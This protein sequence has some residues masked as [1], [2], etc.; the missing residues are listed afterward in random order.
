VIRAEASADDQYAALDLAYA[1]LEMRLRKVADRRRIHYGRHSPKSVADATAALGG[2]NG[3]ATAGTK[4]DAEAEDDTETDT[5]AD[6]RPGRGVS[7][8]ANPPLIQVDGEGPLVMRE[9]VHQASPMTLDQ[10][11]YEMELVGHDFYLFVDAESKLP[12]VVYRRRGYDY[13]VIRLEV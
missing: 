8:S 1:K 3:A 10:A 13:G 2:R 9:K 6:R 7:G 12:S 5:Y 4:A 11:L